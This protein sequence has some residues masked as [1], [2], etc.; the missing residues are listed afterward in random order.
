MS[1]NCEPLSVVNHALYSARLIDLARQPWRELAP[2]NGIGQRS[3]RMRG[4]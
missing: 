1:Q 4:K 2:A 3:L